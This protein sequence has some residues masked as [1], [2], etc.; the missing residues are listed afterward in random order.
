MGEATIAGWVRFDLGNARLGARCAF[1]VGAAE[2]ED[3]DY[4]IA[5]LEKQFSYSAFFITKGSFS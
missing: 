4:C 2:I 3:S 1:T 5:Q